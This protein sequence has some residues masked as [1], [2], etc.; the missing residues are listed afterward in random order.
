M[1]EVD[2]LKIFFKDVGKSKL[3]TREEE[4]SLAKRIENGDTRARDRMISSNIRLAISIAKKY[5]NK[6]CPLEDLIQEDH[7]CLLL[8]QLELLQLLRVLLTL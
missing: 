1:S 3:L 6:G 4:V 5:Q 8:L 2:T 7:I